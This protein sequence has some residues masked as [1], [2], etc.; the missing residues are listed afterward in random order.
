MYRLAAVLSLVVITTVSAQ[1]DV[2]AMLGT[3]LREA[4]NSIFS[5]FVS[6][7]AVLAGE[8]AV[9]KAASPEQRAAIV[10]GVI[11]IARAF[12]FSTDFAQRYALYREAQKPQRSTAARTGDEARAQQQQTIELAVKQAMAGAEQLPAQARKELEAS[13]AAMR[14]QIAELNADPAYRA[15]VDEAAAAA[16]K[17]EDA[18]LAKQLALFD[19][20]FPE[21]VNT[22]IAQRLRQFLLACSDVDFAAQVQQGPDKKLHFVNAAYERRSTEWKMCFRAGKPAVVA[23]RAAAEEWLNVLKNK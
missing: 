11:A 21:D 22:V 12:T 5:S 18:E 9:F 2:L 23:A 8:R 10:R 7:T 6:G 16:A 20:R 17:E 3:N 4:Q 13:I 19:A 1:S 15:Q 14:K